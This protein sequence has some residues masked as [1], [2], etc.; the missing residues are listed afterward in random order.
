MADIIIRNTNGKRK[1]LNTKVDLTPMVD[2]GFL[3]I[4][5]FVFTNTL[6]SNMAMK[7]VMPKDDKDGIIIPE[8]GAVTI[9]PDEKNVWYYEGNIPLEENELAS[10]A[11]SDMNNLRGRLLGLSNRLIQANG[12]NN[13]LMVMI[14]PTSRA[15]FSNMV[16]MLDEMKIC[17]LTRYALL[18]MDA[19]EE[20]LIAKK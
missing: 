2:L 7:L 17:N 9:I 14:K 4:T 20:K 13:K 18:N 15:T 10:I 11:Y 19:N 6:S 5:F 12:N 8:S 16:D 3:L 1:Q